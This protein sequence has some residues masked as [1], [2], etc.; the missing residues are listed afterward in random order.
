MERS[1][2][3]RLALAGLLLSLGLVPAL[4]ARDDTAGLLQLQFADLLFGEERF[5]DAADAYD[6]ARR[7]TTGRVRWQADLGLVKSLLR[8]A[9]FRRARTEAA[10]LVESQPANGPAR[11]LRILLI[12]LSFG[13]SKPRACAQVGSWNHS[14]TSRAPDSATERACA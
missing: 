5:A 6:R 14:T 8:I 11:R 2:R 10:A 4:A 1:S 7:L 9:E 3:I 13:G 12:V